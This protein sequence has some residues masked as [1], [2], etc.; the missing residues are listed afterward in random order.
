MRVQM[1][2]VCDQQRSTGFQIFGLLV[3]RI[4]ETYK[5]MFAILASVE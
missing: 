2:A 1:G 3:S 5:A 4:Y